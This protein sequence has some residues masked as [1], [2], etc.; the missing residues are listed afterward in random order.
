MIYENF[1]NFNIIIYSIK[2]YLQEFLTNFIFKAK[3]TDWNHLLKDLKKWMRLGSKLLTYTVK[4]TLVF[5]FEY[6]I[7]KPLINENFYKFLF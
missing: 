4:W 1:N 7:D 6:F 2:E 3:V 5:S